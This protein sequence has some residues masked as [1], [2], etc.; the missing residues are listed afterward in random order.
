[1]QY[2]VAVRNLC[3]FTAKRGDL[4]LRFTPSPSAQE[5]I[6][7]HTIVQARREKSYQSEIRLS[8]EVKNL[9]VV[10]RADGYD[11]IHNQLEEIKTYRGDINQ[12][13][14]NH[15]SLH[16]AQLKVYG[17]LFCQERGLSEVRL[18]LVY[19]EIGSQQETVISEL[20]TEQ[21]LRHFFYNQC[22]LFLEWSE[23]ELTH[24]AARDQALDTLQFPHDDFRPG[25]RALAEDVYRAT[26]S[27]RCLMVQAPTGIGKTI[28]TIFPTLKACPKQKLDKIF[29]LT[30]KTSGRALALDAL[31]LIKNRAS[32]L[33]LRV[34]E[35]VARDKACE[36]PDKACHGDSCPLAKGFYDRLPMARKAAVSSNAMDKA[37]L[38][39]VALAHEICPYYLSQDMVRWSDVVVGD[40]NYYFDLNAMLYSLTVANQWRVTVLVDEAHNMVERTRKMF[41]AELNQSDC[42]RA[43]REAPMVLKK[44]LERLHRQWNALHKNQATPYQV[45]PTI[46]QKF[47]TTMQ[48]TISMVSEYLNETPI[49]LDS[50]LLR[51]YFDMLQFSHLITMFDSHSLFDISKDI[52]MSKQKAKQNGAILCLRNIIPA[53]FLEQRFAVARS[54]VLFSATLTPS[55]FYSDTLGLPGDTAWIEV[56]SPF[57]PDQLSVYIGDISTR[58]K[59]RETSLEPIVALM[60]GAYTKIQGNYLAFFSSFNYLQQVADLFSIRHPDIPIWIQSRRMVE[61]DR[62]QFL[63]RFSSGG[64]GIG[65]AVLG[66]AFAEGIDLPGNCLI[67]AF[68]ATLGLPPL[69]PVNN[70][71]MQSMNAAF[72]SDVGYDYTYLFPG[73]RKVVQAAGRV[74]RTEFDRG[75][76]HL[77]DDRFTQSKVVSLLPDWWMIK[78]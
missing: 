21:T 74:I 78:N 4:D 16:W 23:K 71:M 6:A 50:A 53:P 18:A 33:P 59:D 42:K 7:G 69:N 46:S 75:T 54:V 32:T 68:I 49:G 36:H 67:G 38:R 19:F 51:F 35:L 64:K 17:W 24:R 76:I 39:T 31:E 26:T 70:Q 65:F 56:E 47:V 45:Y 62:E 52:D 27:G 8:G 57:G 55:H 48:Q 43:I 12:I 77:I 37:S 44:T 5:G 58:Y 72:G 10:G 60:S 66:G 1:M 28:G 41:T 9:R 61:S 22:A 40:Y 11:P 25:Q 73:I 15:R 30:A 13:P 63:A 34:L 29:F 3:E 2:V 20:Y 14:D